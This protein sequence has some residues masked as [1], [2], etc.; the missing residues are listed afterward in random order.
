LHINYSSDISPNILVY[1]ST[2]KIHTFLISLPLVHL[3]LQHLEVHGTQYLQWTESYNPENGSHLYLRKSPFK[4]FAWISCWEVVIYIYIYIYIYTHTHIYI[5]ISG[6]NILCDFSNF[7]SFDI[8][9]HIFL[10]TVT[11]SGFLA[12]FEN[13]L[14][15]YS[16][17]AS[18][19][20]SAVTVFAVSCTLASFSYF[21][22]RDRL[23]L[24]WN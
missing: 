7:S 8:L 12:V 6:S 21:C 17:G 15:T 23:V 14:V 24:P 22:S 1:A 9:L 3:T 11:R 18:S 2:S 19:E 5:Y 20:C 10:I 4:L 16:P 13:D